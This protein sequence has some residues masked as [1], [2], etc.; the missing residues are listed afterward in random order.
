LILLVNSLLGLGEVV[1][2]FKGRT[3][4]AKH[5]AM[6]LYRPS[7]LVLAQ[8]MVDLPL[9]A[10]QVVSVADSRYSDG[11]QVNDP[12]VVCADHVP[13]SHLLYVWS[14]SYCRCFLHCE[15][16]SIAFAIIHA[17]D[18]SETVMDLYICIHTHPARILPNDRVRVQ[19]IPS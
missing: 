13:C 9:V 6:A 1:N 12:A 19:F 18:E 17:N 10:M 5:K 14:T 4:L 3:I 11:F 15:C 16:L 2:S 7:A 8:V